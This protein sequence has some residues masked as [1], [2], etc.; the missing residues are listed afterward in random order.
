MEEREISLIKSCN[1]NFAAVANLI[2]FTDVILH[3][4]ILCTYF[5]IHS[6]LPLSISLPHFCPLS[7]SHPFSPLSSLG[8]SF[9][10]LPKMLTNFF[11]F[12]GN[13]SIISYKL[14]K[15]GY[16]YVCRQDKAIDVIEFFI[17][18]LVPNLDIG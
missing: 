7:L 6:S 4:N 12:H 16:W 18:T 17:V 2:I 14:T 10:F 13:S 11:F 9:F 8:I 15:F 1:L 5:S 3:L